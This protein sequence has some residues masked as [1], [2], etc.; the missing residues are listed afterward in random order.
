MPR[1]YAKKPRKG[2]RPKKAIGQSNLGAALQLAQAAWNGVKY[3][4]GLVNSEVYRLDG[5]ISGNADTT[6]FVV[7]LMAVAQGDGDGART[8]N[9]ILAK[10]LQ[11]RVSVARAGA[12][13]S[14][15]N[16]VGMMIVRDNQ[17]VADTS[18]TIA[19]V[20]ESVDPRA[21]LNSDTV[22]RF[23]ILKRKTFDLDLNGNGGSVFNWY[24]TW[25]FGHHIRYNGT[26]GTDIQR[27]GLYLMV[28]GTEP[29]NAPSVNG[30]FRLS[31]HDN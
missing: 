7:P 24:K 14:V 5:S 22:G 1:R 31:Y 11:I 20:L 17:Q 29:T 13:T 28:V 9:S 16:T 10:S 15:A 18:P 2:G 8:G 23:S 19:Q 25:Q 30:F 4:R 27:E 12:N 3:I 26:A 21:F 6:G